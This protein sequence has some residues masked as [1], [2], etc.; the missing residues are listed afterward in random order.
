MGFNSLD[1]FLYATYQG[2]P[3]QL[4]KIDGQ[5]NVA[6]LGPLN[7]TSQYNVGDVDE[8]G[9]YWA[10]LFGGR[11]QEVDVNPDSPTYLRTLASGTSNPPFNV[12][13][14]AYVPYGGDFLYAVGYNTTSQAILMRFSRTSYAWEVLNNYGNLAGNN[15]FGAIYADDNGDLFGSENT[16]GQ[17]W[18][19]PLS[20]NGTNAVFISKGPTSSQND[21]ARC[22]LM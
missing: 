12:G 1:N 10:S 7:T 5:G 16:S 8:Q 20:S 19:F 2:S 18:R 22:I 21:G 9:H 4:I 11:F 13:D 6:Y 14:W 15:N 17:I 3:L